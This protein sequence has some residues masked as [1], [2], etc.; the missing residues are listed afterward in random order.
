MFTAVVNEFLETFCKSFFLFS[1]RKTV[2][3]VSPIL[4]TLTS[5]SDSDFERSNVSFKENKPDGVNPN[6]N[7]I[8]Y[9][10]PKNEGKIRWFSADCVIGH[11]V[12]TPL[13]SLSIVFTNFYNMVF[14]SMV[15]WVS[16]HGDYNLFS[17]RRA[18]EDCKRSLQ[19]QVSD[20]VLKKTCKQEARIDS[21]H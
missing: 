5:R 20:E 6:S 21:K 13:R 3:K 16:E 19:R 18:S 7:D 15:Y 11:Q 1:L 8:D 12:C 17:Q 14:H 4:V 10:V 2:G 9:Y